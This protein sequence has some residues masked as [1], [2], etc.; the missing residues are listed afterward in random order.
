[1]SDPTMALPSTR[2][3]PTEVRG[4]RITT[5]TGGTI[6]PALDLR[7]DRGS[8][9]GVA[10]ETG[11]GKTTLGLALLG[12]QRP[13]LVR[14]SGVVLLDDDDLG[15][16]SGEGLRRIRGRRIAYVPQDP[17]T[18]LDPAMRIRDALGE[19][20]RAHEVTDHAAQLARIG[21]LFGQVGL[22]HDAA[23]L[24]RFPHQLSGGQQQRVA[25][26]TA[27]LLDPEVVVMDE[28]TTGLDAA[29]K[30][31][32]LALIHDLARRRQ[33]SVLLISH[34]LRMLL[35]ATDRILI[36]RDGVIVEDA[37]ST[38]LP[39]PGMHPY[40]E[41]LLA[42]LP[43][44]TAHR[45]ADHGST[46]GDGLALRGITARHAGVVITDAIDLVVA[47]GECV[48]LVGESGSGKTTLA[49]CIA[50]F[51]TEYSGSVEWDGR[52]LP[53]GVRERALG[54]LR[55]IQYVF[56]NPYASLNPR[57]TVG[58]TLAM[59]ART[60]RGVDR[61]T[62]T[63]DAGRALDRVG[64]DRS[65]LAAPP[66]A[67]SGG[68]RQRIALA[69]A[70][71]AQ[72]RLLVCD[73]VTSSLDV[74]VQAGIIELLMD[75]RRSE[76]LAMLFITHDLALVSSIAARTVVLQRGRIVEQGPTAQVLD[77]PDHP[78]TRMLL[79]HHDATQS[80]QPR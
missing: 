66:Q 28:P 54:D 40:T 27:F 77:H 65:F 23:F 68:Q 6:I 71:I 51:H 64:M 61:A 13:G 74:S 5:T 70:L 76:G 10:G 1:M 44:P 16:L 38:D 19:V 26:A 20:L 47:Q 14:A 29:T 52:V 31:G 36:M 15:T 80:R 2:S 48:A 41:Q 4:L 3:R 8:I 62:A 7:V 78:Y 46:T 57:R 33:A 37:P 21:E 49:R 22:P 75:L 18:A 43:D 56:Q 55:T 34:D 79:S 58:D 42:A 60:I 73:E 9:V 63:A 24:A 53:H 17:G 32:V 67:L 59:A 69:R 39:R 72:P 50:G 35:A 25:I 11:S 12:W 45:V 30:A